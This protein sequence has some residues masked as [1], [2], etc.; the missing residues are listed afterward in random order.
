MLTTERIKTISKLALPVAM[1]L[2]TNLV[3]SLI[4][5]A[6]V[7][8]LG[9]HAIAAA[10][11]ASFS[12]TLVLSLV[13]GIAP[14]VQGMVARRRG[15]GST[16]P[17]CLP[18]NGGLMLAVI[19]GVPM[20]ALCLW[21][22]PHFFRLISTDPEVTKIGVP[23][24]RILYL[25]IIV[26]GMH[27]AFQGFWHGMERPK[28]YMSI[29]LFMV[30]LNIAVNYVLIFGHFG[31]PALGARG[32]AIATL[33]S[34]I[35]G[36]VI[37]FVLMF[38]WYRHEGFLTAKPEMAM[39]MRVVK[40]GMPP[41]MQQFFFSAGY[42]V[43]LR[44]VGQVGTAELAAAN[45][46]V[47][48]SLVLL[49][50]ATALGIASATLVSRTLGEGDHR[51]AS[52]WGWDSGKLSVIG[53]TLLGLPLIVFPRPFLHIFLTDPHTISIAVIPLQ[54]AA[55]TAG[56]GSLIYVFAYTLYS[57]GDGN[58]VMIISLATQWVI[59]LPGVWFVGPHLHYG[60]LHITLVQ[61]VYGA[62]ATAL[63][64]MIWA[65]GRWQKIKI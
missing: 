34:L 39:V 28:V 4:D 54:I 52:Q 24:L 17:K 37:N 41:T 16:A 13:A 29:V 62:I 53:I 22:S 15:E 31:A 1:A 9:N 47:R 46:L 60:L 10:G 5:L 48:I 32:A 14:A 57:V 21:L 26:S 19:I 51:G 42:V 58:R 11:L 12:Y 63:I 43:Y 8:K 44:L 25:S 3:M 35:V 55:A 6:M 23:F 49:I 64:M 30:G 59:F 38:L 18:L 20:T 36:V 56:L 27:R 40:V 61:T 50:L 45:V 33:L 7:G 65:D 2:S